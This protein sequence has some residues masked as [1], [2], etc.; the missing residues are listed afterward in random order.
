MKKAVA[1]RA[2]PS[3]HASP[4]SAQ[5]SAA[6]G[7]P[8][9]RPLAYVFP[10]GGYENIK[11]QFLMGDDLLVAPLVTKGNARTVLIPPGKWKTDDGSVITGPVRKTFDIP[12]TRLLYFERQPPVNTNKNKI[13]ARELAAIHAVDPPAKPFSAST[14]N[15]LLIVV[16]DLGWG[17]VGCYGATEIKSMHTDRFARSGPS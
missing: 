6:S 4:R 9:L 16:S 13:M 15:A 10:D 2:A 1:F 3:R 17:D 12:L 14:P 11:D 5:A 7:E 8:I